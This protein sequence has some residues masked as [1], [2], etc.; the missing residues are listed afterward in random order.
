MS[1]MYQIFTKSGFFSASL[2]TKSRACSGLSILTIGG[3]PR[4]S[5]SR[6]TLEISGPATATRGALAVANRLGQ[7]PDQALA[8]ANRWL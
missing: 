6:E 8:A 5:F 1:T 7:R 4:S 2:R 3:S